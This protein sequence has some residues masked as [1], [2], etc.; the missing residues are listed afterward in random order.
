MRRVFFSPAATADIDAIWDYSAQTWGMDQAEAYV[1][2]FRDACLEL[3]S[4]QRS[5]RRVALREGYLCLPVGRHLLFYRI[6]E[7]RVEVIR[8]LHERMDTDRHF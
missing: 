5:G 4:G 7:A 8:I 3:A 6:I 2:A 1:D